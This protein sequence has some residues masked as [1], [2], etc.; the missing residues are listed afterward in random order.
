MHK[1][2]TG[3]VGDLT[4]RHSSRRNRDGIWH[5]AR[6][7]LLGVACSGHHGRIE[8]EGGRLWMGSILQQE[9]LGR[10]DYHFERRRWEKDISLNLLLPNSQGYVYEYYKY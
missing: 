10:Y 3:D 4:T 9:V 2:S 6:G 8:V 5:P 7:G 1:R